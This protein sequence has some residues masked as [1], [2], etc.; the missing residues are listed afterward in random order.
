M[1]HMIVEGRERASGTC[2]CEKW[3]RFGGYL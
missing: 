1:E 3:W 2:W